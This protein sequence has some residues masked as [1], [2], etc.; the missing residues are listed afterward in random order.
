MNDS[1]FVGT[2]LS[3]ILVAVIGGSFL[4]LFFYVREIWNISDSSIKNR[5]LVICVIWLLFNISLSILF[6]LYGKEVVF[7]G[8]I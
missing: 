8:K 2:I 7:I 6:A 3:N 1:E 5:R 4:M